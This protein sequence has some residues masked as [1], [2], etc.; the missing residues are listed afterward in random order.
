MDS[1]NDHECGT[2]IE[3]YDEKQTYTP[4]TMALMQHAD[5]AVLS[6]LFQRCCRRT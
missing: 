6:L 1:G 5:G 2:I 4:V 3:R